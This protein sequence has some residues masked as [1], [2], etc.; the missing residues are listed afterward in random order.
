VPMASLAPVP[1]EPMASLP[2]PQK[3]PTTMRKIMKFVSGALGPA[4]REKPEPSDQSCA[5]LCVTCK[6]RE[7]NTAFTPC[8]HFGFCSGCATGLQ[9]CPECLE[10]GTPVR[11]HN[12]TK[13]GACKKKTRAPM[14]R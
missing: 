7:K 8:G 6:S 13:F 10:P 12:V 4:R 9:R 1:T 2:R 11:L 5:S 3:P 14:E